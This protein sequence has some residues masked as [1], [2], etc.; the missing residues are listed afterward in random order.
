MDE[1][2][3]ESVLFNAS[4]RYISARPRSVHELKQYL[5]KKLARYATLLPDPESLQHKI[6]FRLS[7]LNFLN[8]QEFIKWWVESRSYFKPKGKRGLEAELRVKGISPDDIDIFFQSHDLEETSLAT[9]VL[10]KKAR[11][12]AAFEPKI[13]TKKATEL[14]LRRGFSYDVA[15]KVVQLF[16][17][18]V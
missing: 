14:L 6:L 9:T 10:E 5:A 3:L 4:L 7:E 8:D 2:E 16:N 15:K 18:P 11:T 17:F 12:L 1:K 13:R